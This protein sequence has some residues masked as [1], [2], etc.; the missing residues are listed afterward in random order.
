V[1]RTLEDGGDGLNAAKAKLD[2]FTRALEQRKKLRENADL[3]NNFAAFF[4]AAWP[5]LE[6]KTP[7]VWSWIYDLLCEWLTLVSTGEFKKR[8]PDLLGL[9]INFPFRS[10]KSTLIICWLVWTWL[11][12][13]H[14]R[15]LCASYSASLSSEHNLKR[16]N[17]ILSRWFQERFGDRFSIVGDRNRIDD[18]ANDKMGSMTATSVGGT[19][20]GYGADILVGDDPNSQDDAYS[21]AQILATNR[22]DRSN[23]A[24]RANNPAESVY[25][26]LSQRI[27]EDDVSGHLLS[28]QKGRFLHLRIPLEAEEDEEFTG[29]ISG[30]VYK[31]KAGDV[32]LP[33]RFTP[34]VVEGLKAQPRVWSTQCQQRPVPE[35]G[36]IIK[37]FWWR[38]YVRPGDARPEGTVVLPDKFDE[39]VQSW[40][41]AFKS[42]AES[43]FV[44]GLLV[45]RVKA[46]KFIDEDIVWDRLDFPQTK[47]AVIA[48][49][50]R[51]PEAHR[52]FVEDKANGSAILAELR[53]ELSGLIAVEPLGSK[54]A[55][56]S[57]AS[58][59]VEAGNVLLPHPSIAPWIGRFID[60][61]AA[62]C[63]GG[64]H[65]DAADALS[66]AINKLR[67]G[68]G[69][70][71]GWIGQGLEKIA[72]LKAEHPGMPMQELLERYGPLK[73]QPY[74]VA[75]LDAQLKA[76]QQVP[77][78][79]FRSR[80]RTFGEL[81]DLAMTNNHQTVHR[82]KLPDL[83][84]TCQNPALARYDSWARC[85]KCGW[86]SRTPVTPQTE[87]P[88]PVPPKPREG[89]MDFLLA[90]VGL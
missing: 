73:S 72:E 65:D 83:C 88:T 68:G 32:I 39:S 34:F 11:R 84:P 64:K 31:R 40:D 89:L 15:F 25:V 7:L 77:D 14:M 50:A 22:W 42:T 86:D 81:K 12:F 26:Y 37:K 35:T 38:F 19:V 2:S 51:H 27:H 16:R 62:A 20:T 33:Q 53:T 9:I 80:S 66:Q 52:K 23:W 3:E 17:L 29:P 21:P 78:D 44:C 69:F 71:S 41:M 61:C 6:P 4:R 24:T 43:D 5:I 60:E 8:Y 10:G 63:C 28:E 1:D 87:Q 48:F 49:S 82:M 46:L 57:A 58:A 67:K 76:K 85:A 54:E 13:P 47:K 59:D 75:D 30:R 18:F 79:R 74:N 56:L 70:M 90:R 55:R 45:H 36:G